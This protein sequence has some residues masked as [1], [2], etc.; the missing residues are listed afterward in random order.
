MT[1]SE[2]TDELQKVDFKLGTHA[3]EME[4]IQSTVNSMIEKVD[5]LEDQF[6]K[7]E[8]EKILTGREYFESNFNDLEDLSCFTADDYWREAIKRNPVWL[9]RLTTKPLQ[10]FDQDSEEG[11]F[12]HNDES[13]HNPHK[14]REPKEWSP[15]FP[16]YLKQYQGKEK[17]GGEFDIAGSTLSLNQ[18]VKPDSSGS[19]RLSSRNSVHSGS[20]GDDDD[21]GPP[22]MYGAQEVQCDGHLTE[23]EGPWE[24]KTT[25]GLERMFETQEKAQDD[26]NLTENEDN[27]ED[28]QSWGLDK[29]YGT[30]KETQDDK[31]LA[32]NEKLESI[33]ASTK[34]QRLL[35]DGVSHRDDMP[36]SFKLGW[37]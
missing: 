8:R 22:K 1:K 4:F 2:F 19:Q 13:T 32:E 20:W 29:M 27:W 34:A 31:H 28:H 25:W 14:M 5:A 18:E 6:K 26:E 23:N 37:W 30:Q 9:T 11:D 21:W 3:L 7:K 15:E 12:S 16:N 17:D 36:G 10:N 33:Q 24:D 35:S